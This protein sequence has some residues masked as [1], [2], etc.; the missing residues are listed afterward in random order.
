MHPFLPTT[1]H[2]QACLFA[3]QRQRKKKDGTWLTCGHYDD[4][5]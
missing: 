3:I 4:A 2:D 1:A 5:V